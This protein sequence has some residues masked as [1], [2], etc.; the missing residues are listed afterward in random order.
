M[1]ITHVGDDKTIQDAPAALDCRA[2]AVVVT[3]AIT[4]RIAPTKLGSA[5]EHAE[6]S[7]SGQAVNDLLEV[8]SIDRARVFQEP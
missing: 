3:Q 7:V 6:R 5:L 2:V 1:F 4:S 8:T